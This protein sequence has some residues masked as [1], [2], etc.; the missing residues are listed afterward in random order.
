MLIIN[1]FLPLKEFIFLILKFSVLH[2]QASIDQAVCLSLAQRF[3]AL[4][5]HVLQSLCYTKLKLLSDSEM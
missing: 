2:I 3:C 4:H 1:I 5:L